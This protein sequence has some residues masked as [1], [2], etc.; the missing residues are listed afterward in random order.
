MRVIVL[1]IV[2][3]AKLLQEENRLL[4]ILVMLSG[5]VIL[6]R[7]LQPEKTDSPRLVKP[8]GNIMLVKLLHPLNALALIVVK[9]LGRVIFFKAVQPE[10]VLALS[11]VQVGIAAL[12]SL[13]HP[14][15]I[16]EPVK[17]MLFGIITLVKPVF[18]NAF[19]PI[20]VTLS[21]IITFSNFPQS[22][23]AEAPIVVTLLENVTLVKFE[24]LS[25]VPHSHGYMLLSPTVVMPSGI[26]TSTKL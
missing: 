24:H 22:K 12:V 8:F 15:N 20:V 23:K 25:N 16:P 17:S 5:I 3:L 10:K 13:V 19:A 6:L 9:V 11:R 7:L 26:I 14:E 21:G 1:G 4:L 2:I 18:A